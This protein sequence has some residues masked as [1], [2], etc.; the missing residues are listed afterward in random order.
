[1]Q[2]RPPLQPRIRSTAKSIA[3]SQIALAEK[4]AEKFAW[5]AAMWH[6]GFAPKVVTLLLSK[7]IVSA[8]IAGVMVVVVDWRRLWRN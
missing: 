8:L 4:F 3:A 6:A 1:M 5:W 7:E 2:S